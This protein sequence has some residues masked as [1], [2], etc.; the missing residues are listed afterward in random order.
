MRKFQVVIGGRGRKNMSALAWQICLIFIRTKLCIFS[1]NPLILKR[2]WVSP[3]A[4]KEG[5]QKRPQEPE[6]ARADAGFLWFFV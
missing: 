2:P 4:T 6:E 5:L 3:G 1:S